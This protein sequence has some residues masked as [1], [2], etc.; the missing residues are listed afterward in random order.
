MRSTQRTA[1]C[2]HVALCATFVS[3]VG[4]VTV[5]HSG[6]LPS[7]TISFDLAPG[8]SLGTAVNAVQQIAKE[9]LPPAITT[10]FAGTAAGVRASRSRACP[11]SSRSTIFV[12]YI[13]LG[14]LY[15]SFI[16]PITILTGSAV[17]GVRR[18]ARRS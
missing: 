2:P 18:A 17:R 8:V 11:C 13:I 16:H 15:E 12:I 3:D 1:W 10:N 9:T 6:Q 4:P 5:N 7:V 14:V